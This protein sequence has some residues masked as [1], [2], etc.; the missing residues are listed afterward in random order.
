MN[1]Y[2]GWIQGSKI[3]QVYVHLSGRDVDD[4][5]LKMN[6]LESGEEKKKESPLKAVRCPRCGNIST[7]NFCYKCGAVL[8]VETAIELQDRTRDVDEKLASLLEDRE[9][10]ELLIRKMKGLA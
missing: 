6:G 3:P 10:R 4:A 7:G 2:L 1:E 9:I 8:N 5:I